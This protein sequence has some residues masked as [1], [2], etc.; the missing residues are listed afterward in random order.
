MSGGH[1]E[2][3]TGSAGPGWKAL[4]AGAPL[5]LPRCLECILDGTSVAPGEIRD[6]H[7][8]FDVPGRDAEG[9]RKIPQHRVAEVEIGANHQARVVE[10]P[11]YQPAVVPPLK[12]PFW[13]GQANTGQSP[14]HACYI[15]HLHECGPSCSICDHALR[16]SC[17]YQGQPRAGDASRRRR[18]ILRLYGLLVPARRPSARRGGHTP[19]ARK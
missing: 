19:A 6:D 4:S 7:H 15:T 17:P 2:M 18:V 8:V 12:P 11:R 10:L 9:L 3:L 5:K 13:R 1:H 16:T 14:G